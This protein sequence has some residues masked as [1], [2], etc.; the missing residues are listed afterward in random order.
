MESVKKTKEYEIVKKRSGRYGVRDAKRNWL[1]G[2]EKVKILLAEKLIQAPAP[3]SKEPEQ[4]PEAS[5]PEGSTQAADEA[6]AD[7]APADEASE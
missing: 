5:A 1:N 6:V 2:D 4:A 3:K 7:E